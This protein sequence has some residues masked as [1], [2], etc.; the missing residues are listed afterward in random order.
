MEKNKFKHKMR[1]DAPAR[2]AGI[3]LIIGICWILLSDS[4]LMNWLPTIEL[5]KFFQSFKGILFVIVTAAIIYILIFKEIKKQNETNSLLFK[6]NQ[7]L[8]IVLQNNSG[9]NILIINKDLKIVLA[10]GQEH[11]FNNSYPTNAVGLD[12]KKTILEEDTKH[13]ILS[14]LKTVFSGQNIESEIKI[15][16]KWYQLR[17]ELLK[18]SSPYEGLAL[19]ILI[20]I[21]SIKKSIEEIDL[22]KEK[23]LSLNQQLRQSNAEMRISK[24]KY[25]SLF[26]NLPDSILILGL[27][28]H[29]QP[30]HIIEVNKAAIN[31]LLLPAGD[32]SSFNLKDAI[33]FGN[34]ESN[35]FN[36]RF[37]A[38]NTHSFQGYLN[39]KGKN[40]SEINLNCNCISVGNQLRLIVI[41]RDI[42]EIKEHQ[43]MYSQAF[44]LIRTIVNNLNSGI[45]VIDINN[46]IILWNSIMEKN[47]HLTE[48]VVMGKS[49]FK[50]CQQ[51]GDLDIDSY[52]KSAFAGNMSYTF[53]YQSPTD[54]K[55][56]YTSIFSP[57]YN[58]NGEIIGVIRVIN[59]I[60]E[61]KIAEF[62]LLKQKERAEQSDYFKSTFIANISHEIRTPMNGIIGFIELMKLEKLSSDQRHYT[63][64]IQNSGQ[65]LL[66][67]IDAMMDISRIETGHLTIEKHWFSM[68]DFFNELEIIINNLKDKNT[69]RVPVNID[70]SSIPNTAMVYNNKDRL[71]QILSNIID[72]SIKYTIEGHIE[73]KGLIDES[74]LSFEVKDTG[75]G[76]AEQNLQLIFQPFMTL[77]NRKKVNAGGIGLGLAICKGLVE[78][79]GG[80]IQGESKE[81]KGT[82][83]SLSIP[84][85]INIINIENRESSNNSSS[86]IKIKKV[87][88]VEDSYES[89]E[90]MKAFL[91]QYNIEVIHAPD[92]VSAIELF[93]DNKDIEMVFCDIQLPD[94]DGFEVLKAIR[95]INNNMI[96]IAQTAYVM[97]EDRKKCLSAGFNDYLPK[98][99]DKS[100]FFEILLKAS[101]P[102]QLKD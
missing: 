51:I 3:Y 6:E 44:S 81:Q 11:I 96:V 57:N 25:M 92:G 102:T 73:I 68:A 83:I 61:R 53:D 90:V 100:S 4:I 45:T 29:Q 8:D 47:T 63:S 36:K 84:I 7:L 71:L 32:L 48:S 10:K 75:I 43:K 33:S 55:N 82:T 95:R 12:L 60:T 58:S 50:V 67:I 78:K 69:Q 88:L 2:I 19:L 21:D 54:N 22:E 1:V 9:V 13:D 39:N 5:F 31:T 41:L 65:Q 17:S 64:I 72:N 70:F 18:P 76:I 91:D 74:N 99:I 14:I 34:D 86:V 87:L 85:G 97:N 98:P 94:I 30:S 56:W 15:H 40:T 26:D 24:D 62:E 27:N 37:K 20:N 35:F 38:N 46:N 77:A 28:E 42:G 52:V 79:M 23:S 59:S 89:T 66:S 101:P 16:N 80:F 49:I 93:F